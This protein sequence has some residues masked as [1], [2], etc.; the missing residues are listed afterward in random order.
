[1]VTVIVNTCNR[2][3]DLKRCLNSL[4][5]QS[6]KDYE[7]LIVDNGS[8]DGTGDLLKEFPVRVITDSIK[9]LSYLFNLGWKNISS[10]IL[11]YLAD[12]AEAD[13]LWLENIISTFERFPE[14]GAVS[15]PIIAQSKQEMHLLYEKA[16]GSPLLKF[17][18]NVYEKLILE[19]KLF[20]PGMLCESGAYSMGAGL[21]ESLQI[22]EC[23][24]VDLLTTSSMGIK[25]S[26]LEKVG[27]FDENFYFNHAD[28]DLFV[29]LKKA[30]YKLIFNPKI[31]ALHYVRPGPSRY[32]YYIG[33]DTAYFFCKDIRPR[34]IRGVVAFLLNILFFNIYWIYKAFAVKELRQL[35]GLI[36]FLSGTFEYI[37]KT[38]KDK[39]LP[40]FLILYCVIILLSY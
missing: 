37:I 22:K 40:S 7:I 28:G 29:R 32:P 4:L 38:L 9:K 33:R 3:D 13:E 19:G 16:Q 18:L 39:F 26:A 8:T 36:G 21:K 15:G 20:Q 34:S 12:D 23:M 6:Y 14:A 30:G 2:K 10:E 24:E 35:Y 11:A 27:G 1:M 5:K 25:R 31:V 17:A